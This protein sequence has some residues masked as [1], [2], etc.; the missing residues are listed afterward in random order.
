MRNDPYRQR[1]EL[2]PK[3]QAVGGGLFLLAV[4]AP[5]AMIGIA[6]GPDGG[7]PAPEE[8]AAIVAQAEVAAEP[9]ERDQLVASLAGAL[10]EPGRGIG[11]LRIGAPYRLAKTGGDPATPQEHVLTTDNWVLAISTEGEDSRISA[12]ELLARD[13][14]AVANEMPLRDQL[15]A[16]D[17][18]ITL[19]THRSRLDPAHA[20]VEADG[21][22]EVAPVE[23]DGIALSFCDQN[24]LVSAIRVMARAD[25]APLAVSDAP[26]APEE[27]SDTAH[28]LPIASLSGLSRPVARRGAGSLHAPLADLSE[29]PEI[30]AAPDTPGARPAPT[31][32]VHWDLVDALIPRDAEDIHD[33]ARK[34]AKLVEAPQAERMALP[35]SVDTFVAETDEQELALS[36]A[37]RR[38]IQ[39]RLSLLGHDTQGVDGIFGP[40]TRDAIRAI[41]SDIGLAA[42]GYL[43]DALLTE[44]RARSETRLAAWRER[45]RSRL[46]L[47]PPID[48]ESVRLPVPRHTEACQR[49]P[50]GRIA[51]NQSISCDLALLEESLKALF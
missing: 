42:T 18:A 16:T 35:S 32:P 9:S 25:G 13:C 29:S 46:A 51:E 36:P 49:D 11:P 45:K 38:E 5:L 30:A 44:I 14:D 26:V 39:L 12:I 47:A 2:S 4:A 27:P 20:R 15:P 31:A 48:E 28:N 8:G 34:V 3:W 7:Q 33:P 40:Q 24:G 1:I 37:E 43:D 17:A 22:G 23:L 50:D 19:G 41:Q 6:S 10:I 21:T